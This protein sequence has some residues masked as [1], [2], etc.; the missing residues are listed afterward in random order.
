MDSPYLWRLYCEEKAR[1]CD[2]T[3]EGGGWTVIQQRGA[4]PGGGQ[5]NFSTGWQEYRAG[6]GD[7]RVSGEFWA[8]NELISQLTAAT[9][10][11][12]RVHLK[13]HNGSTAFA[14]YSTF[15]FDQIFN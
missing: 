2:Q 3:T 15:R 11:H 7:L 14:E 4:F 8:G 5:V 10:T 1:L 6:F 9:A 13:A 12:L